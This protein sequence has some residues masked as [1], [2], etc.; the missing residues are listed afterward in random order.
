LSV[1]G[2]D[3]KENPNWWARR[4]LSTMLGKRMAFAFFI[5]KPSKPAGRYRFKQLHARELRPSCLCA[6][7]LDRL[8]EF[9]QEDSP[10][11]QTNLLVDLPEATFRFSSET[12]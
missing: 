12:S 8:A 2:A 3:K 9:N 7:P 4:R 11:G 6:L 5:A 1:R 10:V